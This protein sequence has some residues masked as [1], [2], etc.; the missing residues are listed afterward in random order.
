MASFDRIESWGHEII[1]DWVVRAEPGDQFQL[2]WWRGT[3]AEG[4][5][6]SAKPSPSDPGSPFSTGQHNLQKRSLRFTA[7]CSV[8]HTKLNLYM[9][10]IPYTRWGSI[11]ATSPTNQPRLRCELV[12]GHKIS[13][14]VTIFKFVSV[15]LQ[16][17][18]FPYLQSLPLSL[19]LFS[20]C[21]LIFFFPLAV[22]GFE[23]RA[24]NL[25]GKHSITGAMPTALLASVIFQV[26]SCVFAW[27]QPGIMI[28]LLPT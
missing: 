22:L 18:C 26:R 4:T 8:S 3:K 23:L 2:P 10:L 11:A 24:L 28:H 13:S 27:G 7:H 25:L 16:M 1:G 5:R 21:L 6:D 19:L 9:T 12:P 20:H 14:K 15:K 17:L